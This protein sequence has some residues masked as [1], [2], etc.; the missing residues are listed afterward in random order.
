MELLRTLMCIKG[1]EIFI[2]GR[3]TVGTA[4]VFHAFRCT[5]DVHLALE[6]RYVSPILEDLAN[7]SSPLV[8]HRFDTFSLNK[9]VTYRFRAKLT[10]NHAR[11]S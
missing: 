8:F 2:V 7:T 6:K 10:H 9:N 1:Q 4:D 5:F 3:K 11:S